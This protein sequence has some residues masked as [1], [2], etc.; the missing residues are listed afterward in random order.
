MNFLAGR[1]FRH[2]AAGNDKGRCFLTA[3]LNYSIVGY[4]EDG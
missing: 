4:S 3:R 1:R 2:L